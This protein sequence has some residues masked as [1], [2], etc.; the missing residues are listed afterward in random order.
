MKVAPSWMVWL[1][2]WDYTTPFY[3][4]EFPIQVPSI[5]GIF[6]YIYSSWCVWSVNIPYMDGM[7]NNYL[8]HLQDPHY[9]TSMMTLNLRLRKTRSSDGRWFTLTISIHEMTYTW[10]H[11]MCD[12]TKIYKNKNTV[13]FPELNI[14]TQIFQVILGSNIRFMYCILRE[15]H[16]SF[17]FTS[18]FPTKT[19]RSRVLVSQVSLN[20]IISPQ[21]C[22]RCLIPRWGCKE[23][24]CL[25]LFGCG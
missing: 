18:T 11:F 9:P 14:Y 22:V 15:Q 17:Y 5:Y 21:S 4:D 6:T 7:G 25:D 16:H 24:T 2:Q 1:I 10:R 23:A 3:R 20:G 19:A 13:E 12:K 8:S